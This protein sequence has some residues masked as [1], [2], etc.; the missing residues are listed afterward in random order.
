MK[1]KCL[2]IKVWPL[3]GLNFLVI[4]ATFSQKE[5]IHLITVCTVEQKGPFNLQYAN[6]CN[7]YYLPIFYLL[8]FFFKLTKLV[9]K[10]HFSS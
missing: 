3:Y 6:S 9:K 8:I 5:E 1:V 10:S 7:I 4:L 2:L